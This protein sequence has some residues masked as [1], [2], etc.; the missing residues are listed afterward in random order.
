MGS[1]AFMSQGLLNGC[2][3][4][5]HRLKQMPLDLQLF[6]DEFINHAGENLSNKRTVWNYLKEP[7]DTKR[8]MYANYSS[9][10]ETLELSLTTGDGNRRIEGTVKTW[11]D[12]ETR[13]CPL[14]DLESDENRSD[15]YAKCTPSVGCDAIE[16]HSKG[17]HKSQVSVF[18]GLIFSTGAEKD[19]SLEI[20]ESSSFQEHSDCYQE[21]TSSSKGT[22]NHYLKVVI[23][24]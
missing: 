18:S 5:H 6:A 22:S 16:M 8:P 9:D 3:D 7:I 13:Y 10:T 12:K 2:E 17:N 21:Q 15:D 24:F 23:A 19:Q 1:T 20:A 11:F 4:P 14:I